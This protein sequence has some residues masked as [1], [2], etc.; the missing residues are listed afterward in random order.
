MQ[1]GANTYVVSWGEAFPLGINVVGGKAW[2]LSRLDRYGFKIPCGSV[3]TT[4]AF[5]EFID[6]NQLSETL[7]LTSL[8]INSENLGEA[9]DVLCRLREEIIN[10][11]IPP[12]VVE[13]IQARLV[14]E[15]LDNKAVAVRSSASAEDSRQASFA[16]IHDTFLN[17]RGLENIMEAI[18]GCYASL[19][20]PRAVA[21]RRKQNIDDLE[22]LSAVVIMEM[23]EARSAGVAFSCDPQSG[24][25]DVYVIN[26]NFGLGESV[27]SGAIEPDTYF[28][29][30]P[31]YTF[32]PEIKAKKLGS[33]L[34]VTRTNENGGIYLAPYDDRRS[35]QALHDE[36][37]KR[38]GI[39]I[40]RVFDSLG[41][42]EEP[43]DIE[44]AFDGNDFAL[45][46]ARPVTT[47]PD[48]TFE[49]IKN[50][51][52]VW[53][54]A[55]YRDAIPIVL[56]PLHR[57]I[58]K[59]II[60]TIWITAFSNPGYTVP[61]G[62]VFS[63]F[64]NGR[65]YC[66]MSAVYWAHYDCNGTLPR[67]LT[68]FWGGHQPEIEIDDQSP[69]EGE[70]GVRRQ[71]T[72]MRSMALI[73]ETTA[74]ASDI[75]SGVAA[76]AN[77]LAGEGF[78]SLPDHALIDKFEDL[79]KIVKSYSGKYTW[80]SG[81]G[82]LP[83]GILMQNLFGVL[84]PKTPMVINGLMAGGDASITS[85]DH[86]YRLVELAEQARQDDYAVRY[87]N[88][89]PFAPLFWEQQLPENSPFKQA[90][91]KF[92]K[93][94]G[95]RAIYELDI[96]NP[97]WQEDPSYLLDIIRTTMA[98]ANLDDLRS[99][100]KEKFNQAWAEIT[101]LLPADKLEG[102]R[103]MIIDAQ[104]GAGLREMAK[105]V[106]VM[107]LQPY[108]S[109]ALELGDRFARR[110]LIDEPSD[111]FFCT[112]PEIFSILRG[113]WNAIGLKSLVQDRIAT[114]KA[115][116]LLIPPDIIQ[117]DNI[118]YSQPAIII[119]SG[120]YLQ[121][122]GAAAGKATGIARLINHPGEG[123]KLR[124]GDVLVAPSTDPG[125]T[126]LFLKACAVIMETGGYI[127]HGAIIAREYGIPTV[128][129]VPGVMKAIQ[130]GQIVTVD[131]DEGRI[132]LQ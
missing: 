21:Y 5:Q 88:N 11:T 39:L 95:H 19:W 131:G 71:K 29:A 118:T 10:A 22:L 38:L 2:N 76:A 108:R 120:N 40:T 74:N 23:V 61:D 12:I 113:E 60:D 85:A 122:V 53:S 34:G 116:E 75:L 69:F 92:I 27:V 84:G 121:G 36:D 17:V 130:D 4:S 47:L 52:T 62:I 111:I 67:D 109:M 58:L 32:L 46:Q 86:G 25:R 56:S 115:N 83:L 106:L 73:A 79:G 33:K 127:S 90:F 81:A 65:L 89:R 125:W 114:H 3:L 16:G 42:G 28:L 96:I 87:F 54:N 35:E 129:N 1:K 70:A 66:N 44:W 24:R 37:I 104:Q 78:E 82:G 98:T 30:P 112:W 13:A 51:S 119:P 14:A 9:D 80:L 57:Q 26:A 59:D 97:R 45:L 8:Q 101:A 63:R 100:Q 132:I 55:N 48:C 72:A 102:I 43:Q 110:D 105:S 6:Y 50:Q 77:D 41:N 124:S 93:K 103:K 7:K 91:H 126:P 15:G 64:F 68:F 99:R 49:A 128:I 123:N 31:V 117:G 20:T 107:A 18:K 94:Y